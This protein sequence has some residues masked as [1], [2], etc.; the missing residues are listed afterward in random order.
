MVKKENNNSK[1]NICKKWLKKIKKLLNELIKMLKN[2][3]KQFKMLLIMWIVIILII[4]ILFVLCS[5]N[6]KTI[7]V[8][9]KM[10]DKISEAAISYVE[11]NGIYPTVEQKLRLNIETLFY[12]EYLDEESVDNTC[13]GYSIVFFDEADSKYKADSY[14]NCD[15][16]V[17]KGYTNE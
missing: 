14:I 16:Y 6:N 1:K 4:M 3:S 10:E 12:S 13:S 5:S 17:T 7:Q 15:K 8:H 9:Q 11:E 2:S